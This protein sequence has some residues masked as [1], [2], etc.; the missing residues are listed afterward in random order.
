MQNQEKSSSIPKHLESFLNS[1]Q[2]KKEQKLQNQISQQV[3]QNNLLYVVDSNT[4]EIL[5]E[6][7]RKLWQ[8]YYQPRLSEDIQPNLCFEEEVGD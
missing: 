8:H 1:I 4:G 7:D 5:A 6:T 2:K 3:Q